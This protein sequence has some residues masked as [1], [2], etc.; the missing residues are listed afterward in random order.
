LFDTFDGG[1]TTLAMRVV[2]AVWSPDGAQLAILT[3]AGDGY[4]LSAWDAAT[5]AMSASH[6]LPTPYDV[7]LTWLDDHRVAFPALSDHTEYRW[8]DP[9]TGAAGRLVS[10]LGR[11]MLS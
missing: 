10:G 1:A 5:R 9:V 4:R 2:R 11:T 3:Q 7:E 8:L 6:L